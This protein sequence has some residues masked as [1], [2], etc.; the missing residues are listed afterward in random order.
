[1]QEKWIGRSEG[2]RIRFEF[3]S[4]EAPA[5]V[6]LEVFTTRPDTLFG[7]SFMA[8]APDHPLA[9]ARAASDSNLAG[10]I[11]ECRHIGTSAAEIETAEKRGYDTGLRRPPSLR[12]RIGCCRSSSRTSS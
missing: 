5:P 7:A 9:A 3:E 1:M 11:E 10:F 4:A 8:V 2:L 12:C 6:Q